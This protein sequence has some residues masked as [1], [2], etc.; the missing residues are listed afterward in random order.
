MDQDKQ[1]QFLIEQWAR[2]HDVWVK[3]V[4]NLSN[5]GLKLMGEVRFLTDENKKLKEELKAE[6]TKT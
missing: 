2:S 5:E 3:Q 4:K 6:M 1:I